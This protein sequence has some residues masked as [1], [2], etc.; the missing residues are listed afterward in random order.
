MSRPFDPDRERPSWARSPIPC[1]DCGNLLEA[2]DWGSPGRPPSVCRSCQNKRYEARTRNTTQGE[3]RR[4]RK[5]LVAKRRRLEARIERDTAELEN[6][7]Q[8]LAANV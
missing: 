3:R 6:V 2:E 8:A 1:E 5:A 7:R 4:R